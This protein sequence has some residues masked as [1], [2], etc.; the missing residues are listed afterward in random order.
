MEPLY[1]ATPGLLRRSVD[2]KQHLVVRRSLKGHH[3]DYPVRIPSAT[4][5]KILR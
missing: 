4:H 3:S 2:F 5:G 1:R